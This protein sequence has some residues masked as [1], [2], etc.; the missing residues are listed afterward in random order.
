MEYFLALSK[1]I[2]NNNNNIANTT[3]VITSYMKAKYA[4]TK[5]ISTPKTK[6]QHSRLIAVEELLS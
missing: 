5:N 3:T 2:K 1:I 4:K 6:F